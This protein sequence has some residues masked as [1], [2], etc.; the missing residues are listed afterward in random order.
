MGH[1]GILGAGAWGTALARLQCERGEATR[2]WTWQ[3][4]HAEAMQRERVN[5]AFLR[6]FP[7]PAGLEVSADLEFTLRG[8][9]AVILVVPTAG[10]RDTLEL[11][12]PYIAQDATLISRARASSPA[13]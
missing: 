1:L 11:A 8:A 10:F 5:H 6:G 7:L 3:A 9:S 12:R 2:L 4:E 13:R